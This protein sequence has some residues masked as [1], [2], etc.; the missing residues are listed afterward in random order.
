MRLFKA[1]LLVSSFRKWRVS[2]KLENT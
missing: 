2:R 1:I